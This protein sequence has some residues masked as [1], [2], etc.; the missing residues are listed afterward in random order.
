MT[1]NDPRARRLLLA[2]YAALGTLG[3]APLVRWPLV[4]A[5]AALAV[6]L[7]YDP[8]GDLATSTAEAAGH[9]LL[10]IGA[11][12]IAVGCVTLALAVG[13]GPATTRAVPRV[14]AV[15]VVGAG[16]GL[17]YG[18]VA[19]VSRV[20]WGI[21]RLDLARHLAASLSG[22]VLLLFGAI[23]GA[24]VAAARRIWFAVAGLALMAGSVA[25]GLPDQLGQV[26]SEVWTTRV[27][28][29]NTMTVVSVLEPGYVHAGSSPPPVGPVVATGVALAG[30]AIAVVGGV[31]ASRPSVGVD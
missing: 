22:E 11:L 1:T 28:T 17:G 30:I 5:S 16:L 31:L 19:V 25:A 29:G 24:A 4:P 12:A 20:W 10:R 14:V 2:G 3:A 21:D 6:W 8:P 23:A 18:F 13:V 9:S 7:T 15:A 27:P 26:A